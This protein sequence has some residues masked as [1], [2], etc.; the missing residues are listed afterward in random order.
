MGGE[1]Q[2]R[3]SITDRASIVAQRVSGHPALQCYKSIVYV[4]LATTGIF[5][6]YA[7]CNSA[8]SIKAPFRSEHSVTNQNTNNVSYCAPS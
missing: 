1:A 8:G 3:K 6:L 5:S 2:V 4:N 7:E